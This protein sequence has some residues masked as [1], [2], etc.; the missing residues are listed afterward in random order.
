MRI[1]EKE[2]II[3]TRKKAVDLFCLLSNAKYKLQ[4]KMKSDCIKYWKEFEKV[5]GLEVKI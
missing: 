3:L 5:L 1:N 4:G 2:E